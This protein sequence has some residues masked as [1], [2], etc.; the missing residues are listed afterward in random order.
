MN[1]CIKYILNIMRLYIF[2]LLVMYV[3]QPMYDILEFKEIICRLFFKSLC[4]L[5]PPPTKI[6]AD[7]HFNVGYILYG[8][9]SF[10]RLHIKKI[11]VPR[12]K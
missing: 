6:F 3:I 5:F 4:R 2:Y 12:Y 10:L 8:F 7:T 11:Y 9:K 1:V